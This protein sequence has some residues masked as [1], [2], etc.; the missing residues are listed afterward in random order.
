[1][2]QIYYNI[3]YSPQSYTICISIS[4]I[5]SKTLPHPNIFRFQILMFPIQLD[6]YF[7]A[8]LL[9]LIFKGLLKAFPK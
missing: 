8:K 4:Q 7:L 5:I 2:L 6:S 1:M 3:L 9:E